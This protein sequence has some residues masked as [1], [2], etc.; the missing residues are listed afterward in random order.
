MAMDFLDFLVDSTTERLTGYFYK[1]R[2][3][4]KEDG[5]IPFQYEQLDPNNKVFDKV[6]GNVRADRAT[7]AIKTNDYSDFNI[8]GYIITQNGKIWEITEVITNEQTKNNND[9]L[10]W[11]REAKNVECSVRMIEIDDLTDQEE[12]YSKECKVTIEI[13]GKAT[14]INKAI[15]T[16]ITSNE[17]VD[18][19]KDGKQITFY[20]PKGAYAKGTITYAYLSVLKDIEFSVSGY[21]TKKNEWFIKITV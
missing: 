8:G 15:V 4:T 10:W 14:A 20:I 18:Y 2:P 21:Q 17:S 6:L 3:K 13:D 1:R 19:K 9:A 5:R 11:F 7:Y 12:S 16:N